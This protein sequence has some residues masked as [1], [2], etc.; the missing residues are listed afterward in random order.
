[1]VH[2]K[3]PGGVRGRTITNF[4]VPDTNT[5]HTHTHFMYSKVKLYN[6]NTRA[7]NV[8]CAI[9]SRAYANAYTY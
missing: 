9:R 2:W 4:S 5:P 1:M 6:K 7:A 3:G 8:A